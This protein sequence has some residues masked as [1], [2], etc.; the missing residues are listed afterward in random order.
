[1]AP[2]QST[3]AETLLHDIHATFPALTWQKYVF[4]DRGWD[5]N[6]ILL[7][8]VL[9]FRFPKTSTYR[10]LFKSE[11]GLLQFL[12]RRLPVPIPSYKYIAPDYRFGGYRLL[13]GLTLSPERFAQL[14]PMDRARIATQ[15]AI[16]LASLHTTP[17]GA[18]DQYHVQR[19][20]IPASHREIRARTEKHL[21]PVLSPPDYILA[22]T[23]VRELEAIMHYPVNPRLIHGGISD[24]HLLWDDR[25]KQIGVIDFS[26]RS[27]GDPAYD[28]AELY[29][30]G[31]QFVQ[32]VMQYYHGPRDNT[33]LHRARVFY[34][35]TA[36]SNLIHSFTDSTVDFAQAKALFDHMLKT[37]SYA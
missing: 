34:R 1:M 24:R 26:A 32:E 23:V 28:F 16:F 21:K 9:L 22:E 15:M 31:P 3:N 4:S 13:P 6:M 11:V 5:Q 35:Q 25:A 12:A 10:D 14:T 17:V 29:F 36:I 20:S 7:D 18:L 30:Y 33:L 27:L 2:T 37:S 8:D 19:E